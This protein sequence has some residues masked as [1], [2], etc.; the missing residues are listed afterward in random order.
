MNENDTIKA[1]L[2]IIEGRI[3][4]REVTFR[5]PSDVRNYI[6]LQ[7]AERKA[8]VFAVIFVDNRHRVIEYRELFFGTIDNTSVYPR[9]V[10]RAVMD[11]NAAAVVLVHNHP[12]GVGEPSQADER[13]T[14]R[15]IQA[16]ELIDVRVLD[17]FIV[18]GTGITSLAER[19]LM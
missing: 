2:A 17:H 14:R 11:T 8:E 7:L 4:R 3:Q 10:V 5:S 13:I 9:E 15:L 12:S 1:A 19:G 18:A 6:T 16:L